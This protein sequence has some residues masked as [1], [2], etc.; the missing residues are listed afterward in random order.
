MHKGF[1]LQ[2]LKAL[3]VENIYSKAT[4]GQDKKAHLC[5]VAKPALINGRVGY[6]CFLIKWN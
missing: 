2:Y 6:A 4:F 5:D 3:P 1:N